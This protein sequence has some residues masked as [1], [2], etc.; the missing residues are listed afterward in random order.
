MSVSCEKKI[1]RRASLNSSSSSWVCQRRSSGTVFYLSCQAHFGSW[2]RDRHSRQVAQVW[3][4]LIHKLYTC[5]D[6]LKPASKPAP[7]V[8]I[9]GISPLSRVTWANLPLQDCTDVAAVLS[10]YLVVNFWNK[11]SEGTYLH[12][13][14]ANNPNKDSPLPFHSCLRPLCMC[15]CVCRVADQLQCF[16]FLSGG[17]SEWHPGV[18]VGVCVRSLSSQS[19]SLEHLPLFA[20][21]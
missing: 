8:S 10:A 20:C 1:L 4:E 16:V 11:T 6:T 2:R 17:Q 15:F 14:W 21:C 18:S 19:F 12:L 5:S 9:T 13:L 7:T 3:L